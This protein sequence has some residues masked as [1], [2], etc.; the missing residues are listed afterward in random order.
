MKLREGSGWTNVS[1]VAKQDILPG[2]ANQPINLTREIMTTSKKQSQL[3]AGDVVVRKE[4]ALLPGAQLKNERVV[5]IDC[6]S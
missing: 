5:S 3:K 1:S 4:A 2:T 6:R